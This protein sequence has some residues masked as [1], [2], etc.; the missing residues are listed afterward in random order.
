MKKIIAVILMAF[1]TIASQSQFSKAKLQASGL[2]CSMCSKAVKVAL[3]KVPFVQEVKVN[4]KS[5]EYAIIFKQNNNADFDALKKAVEDAGFSV[6]SL[7]V[8][9]SF[10]NVNVQKDMHLQLDGK[11]FHF[12]SSSDKV[13]NGEQTFT[14][15]DKDFL[16][17]KDYKK[18]SA[19]TKMECIKTGKAG[20]CCVKDGMHSEDRVYHVVI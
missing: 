17:A 4:I 15:V 12:I 13:L 2:T 11:N 16:S 1:A 9:G 19:A 6:A 3:E 10:S 20:N 5:Q 18:Y 14:I 7:K 8:T